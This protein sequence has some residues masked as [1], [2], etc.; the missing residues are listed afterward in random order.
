MKKEVKFILEQDPQKPIEKSILAKA[1]LEISGGM[2]KL[3]NSGINREAVVI[4]LHAK[5]GQQGGIH[6]TSKSSVRAV[7]D[8]I[9]QLERDY[10]H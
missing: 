7:L 8:G 1:I 2:R 9:A 5:V 6:G 10:C 4:L 3:L